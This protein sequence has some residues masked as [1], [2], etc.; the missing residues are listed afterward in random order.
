MNLSRA[1]TA[2]YMNLDPD[3]QSTDTTSNQEDGSSS[4]SD[5]SPSDTPRRGVS[6][7]R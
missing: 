1:F 7:D 2:H 6:N 4:N 5:Y 3:E